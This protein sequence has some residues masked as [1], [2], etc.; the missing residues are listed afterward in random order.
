MYRSMLSVPSKWYEVILVMEFTSEDKCRPAHLWNLTFTSL[1]PTSGLNHPIVLQPRR[2]TIGSTMV[3]AR[4]QHNTIQNLT[5]ILCQYNSRG[6]FKTTLLFPAS[7][8]YSTSNDNNFANALSKLLSTNQHWRIHFN[9]HIHL[10]PF[11]QSA[12]SYI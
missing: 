12:H 7:W 10:L 8:F 4:I 5:T 6:M 9:S 3:L 2:S 1:K 11:T